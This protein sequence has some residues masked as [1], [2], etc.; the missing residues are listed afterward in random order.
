VRRDLFDVLDV[1]FREDTYSSLVVE[2]LRRSPDIARGVFTRYTGKTPRDGAAPDIL[3]RKGIGAQPARNHPDIVIK[4]D[5]SDG[6]W[7]LVIEAKVKSDEGWRQTERYRDECERAKGRG[8]CAG[9]TLLFMTLAGQAPASMDWV[10]LKHASL[11]GTIGAC[12]VE[13]MISGDPVLASPWEA[14]RARL[15][16]YEALET[17]GDDESLVGWLLGDSRDEYFVSRAERAAK[18]GRSLI[19][20]PYTVCPSIYVAQGREQFLVQAYLPLWVTGYWREGAPLEDCISVH[21]EVDV[22]LPFRSSHATCHLHCEANPYMTKTK[23]DR[24]GGSAD[25]FR[26]LIRILENNIHC[27]ISGTHWKPARSWLQKAKLKCP[28]TESTTV[29]GFRSFLAPHLEQLRDGIGAAM[30]DAGRAA[31]VSWWHRFG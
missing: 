22:M 15:R 17:P 13:G 24:L 2:I 9:F 31:G 1:S 25:R 18:L 5:T 21:F 14:Y 19:A 8:E 28:L 16:H 12:D 6:Q 11:A 4:C 3:F 23:V 27:M 20:E 29:G 26:H 30:R 10:P 7:W